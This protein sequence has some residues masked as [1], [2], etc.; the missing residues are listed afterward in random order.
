[1]WARLKVIPSLSSG[2]PPWLLSTS[3]PSL[4][5]ELLLSIISLSS[6]SLMLLDWFADDLSE[7]VLVLLFGIIST[8]SANSLMLLDWFADDLSEFVLVLLFGIISTV[9]A[10]SFTS[11]NTALWGISIFLTESNWATSPKSKSESF[12]TA[13]FPSEPVILIWGGSLEIESF[14]SK[15]M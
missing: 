4:V 5:A 1:M 10:N 11:C 3:L 15:L 9:S 2:V 8:I 7:F 12:A 13:I 14:L 6:N